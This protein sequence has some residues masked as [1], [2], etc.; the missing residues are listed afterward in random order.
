MWISR[1]R[2]MRMRTKKTLRDAGRMCSMSRNRNR[3]GSSLRKGSRRNYRT[4]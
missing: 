4:H 1:K 3:N 2:R